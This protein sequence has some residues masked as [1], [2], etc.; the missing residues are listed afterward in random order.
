MKI[1]MNYDSDNSSSTK[2]FTWA[3]A[4]NSSDSGSMDSYVSLPNNQNMEKENNEDISKSSNADSIHYIENSMD[5]PK[6]LQMKPVEN[7]D[8]YISKKK[9]KKKDKYSISDNLEDNV[10]NDYEFLNK[11]VKQE[12]DENNKSIDFKVKSRKFSEDDCNIPS[13]ELHS[14][15]NNSGIK[16]EKKKKNKHKILDTDVP[17]SD[18]H[19]IDTSPKKRKSKYKVEV[20]SDESN[21]DHFNIE[22]KFCAEE[23]VVQKPHSPYKG[24]KHNFVD[25]YDFLN[26]KVKQEED[27]NNKSLVLKVKS[28]KFN[29]NDLNIT[30]NKVDSTLNNSGDKKEKKKKKRHKYLDADIT[31]SDDQKNDSSSK[32]HKS[33]CKV[34][35]KTDESN[36]ENFDIEDKFCA[37]ETVVQKPHS[38]NKENEY[39]NTVNNE[40]SNTD[41]KSD[42]ELHEN[43]FH[44]QSNNNDLCIN[45]REPTNCTLE[46]KVNHKA[47]SESTSITLLNKKRQS[48]SKIIERIRFE[49]ETDTDLDISENSTDKESSHLKKILL[50]EKSFFEPVPE[51][52]K[53]YQK[54]TEDDELWLVKCPHNLGIVDFSNKELTLDSKSKIKISGE[55]YNGTLNENIVSVTLMTPDKKGFIIKNVNINGT[56]TLQK[57]LSRPHIVEDNVMVNNQTDFIPLPETKYHHPLFG[58][59]YKNALKLPSSITQRLQELNANESIQTAQIE[60]KKRKKRK[61]EHNIDEDKDIST[62]MKPQ[63]ESD[64]SMKKAK[65]RKHDNDNEVT[66]KKAKRLKQEFDSNDVWES[67]KAIE[68]NLFNF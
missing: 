13:D 24:N 33:K 44:N 59:N 64:I 65:K 19:K 37:E 10:L 56:V 28:S 32:K 11:K 55:T 66:A 49:D 17:L 27:E 43:S 39:E 30:S 46:K 14:T 63:I 53:S 47:I 3:P 1:H 51:K 2:S 31:L 60:K 38:P 41:Y 15:L 68:E 25:D 6:K 12:E 29:E 20:K 16:K 67:E 42:D 22:D 61:Y 52:S 5:S 40:I 62:D 23:T 45:R 50:K 48:T 26:R 18:D 58:S 4:S 9:K 54:I 34:E 8:M 36:D 57:R 35:I 21:N 7:E